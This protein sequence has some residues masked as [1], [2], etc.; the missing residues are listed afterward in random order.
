M[1][2]TGRALWSTIPLSSHFFEEL[3]LHHTPA[4][5]K[6]AT[7]NEPVPNKLDLFSHA[8]R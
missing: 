5:I 3:S 7:T 2:E 1:T 4:Q 6:P 8:T